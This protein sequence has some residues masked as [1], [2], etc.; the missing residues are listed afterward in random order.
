MWAVD[1][2]PAE[3]VEVDTERLHVE[4]SVRRVGYA[5]DAE[6]SGGNGVDERGDWMVEDE[7]SE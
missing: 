3:G 2:V 4:G 7:V 1:F 6:E 5:V